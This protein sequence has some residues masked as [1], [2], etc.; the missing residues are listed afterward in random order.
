VLSADARFH[1]Y[2]WSPAGPAFLGQK[3]YLSPQQSTVYR[4]QAE[5]VFGCMWSNTFTINVQKCNQAIWFA[6]AFSPNDDGKND[7]YTPAIEG[8]LDL[9]QFSIYNRWGRWYLPPPV[10]RQGGMAM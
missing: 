6:T 7:R 10:S 9:Y 8:R 1:N 2:A 4:V 5:D 3:A